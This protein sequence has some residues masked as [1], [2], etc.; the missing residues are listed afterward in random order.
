M[1]MYHIVSHLNVTKN[2][3]KNI[4]QKLSEEKKNCAKV[5]KYFKEFGKEA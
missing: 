3:Y 2:Q 1:I 4:G 5:V